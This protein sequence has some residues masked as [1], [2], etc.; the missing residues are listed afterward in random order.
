MESAGLDKCL[1]FADVAKQMLVE[2]GFMEKD[3]PLFDYVAIDRDSSSKSQLRKRGIK[4]KKDRNHTLKSFW[5][6][7]PKKDRPS[8]RLCKRIC[9]HLNFLSRSGRTTE[10]IHKWLDGATAYY[11][12]NDKYDNTSQ[13][14]EIK[15][16]CDH[17]K[18]ADFAKGKNDEKCHCHTIRKG[19]PKTCPFP[20]ICNI[21]N[22]VYRCDVKHI[23][24]PTIGKIKS[25]LGLTKNKLKER[26]RKHLAS[27]AVRSSEDATTLS[28]YVHDLKDC[29]VEFEL[30]W[31]IEQRAKSYNG[32]SCQL[33]LAE[34]SQ[35]LF[36][37]GRELLNQRTELFEAC[38]H[39]EP[40]K[41]DS[42]IARK[43]KK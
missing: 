10:E 36:F 18:A 39:Q 14:P 21:Q 30:K 32:D 3:D 1:Q 11:S 7:V 5:K 28:Q 24:G 22:V 16:Y 31:K 27:F 29:G 33:C 42:Q 12:K 19:V 17:L 2:E 26:V 6:V 25:Y 43:N 37:P 38:R 23:S 9:A 35:I 34:K 40:L 8:N 4:N 20:D 13:L 15:T 41:F